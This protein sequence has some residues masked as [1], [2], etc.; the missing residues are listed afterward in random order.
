VTPT[1]SPTPTVTATPGAP[2]GGCAPEPLLACTRPLR[3]ESG[4]LA[5]KDRTPDKNDSV[6]WRWSRG[7]IVPKAEFG[8]PLSTTSYRLCVYDVGAN[9][10][11]GA[12]APAGGICNAKTKRACWRAVRRGFTYRNP[13]RALG[14]LQSLDLREGLT[15]NAAR[16]AVRG[17]GAL[18][19]MRNPQ[20]LTLPLTVQLQ[21]SN[22]AC[23][24]STYSRPIKRQSTKAFLD[25]AD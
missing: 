2:A 14:A 11:L 12:A 21:A 5:L 24:G 4:V 13:D 15:V 19:A 10:V 17:R 1:A 25:D 16:I 3:A 23:F 6:S 9:L 7:P 18:L 8:D 22:G 20:S